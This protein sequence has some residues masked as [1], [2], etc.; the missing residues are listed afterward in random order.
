MNAHW[1][2]CQFSSVFE[3]L[4]PVFE[5][6]GA[7]LTVESGVLIGVGNKGGSGMGFLTDFTTEA[8][9]FKTRPNM[10]S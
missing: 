8:F 7:A 6:N 5:D 10:V 3:S 9:S 2:M 4:F 1:N